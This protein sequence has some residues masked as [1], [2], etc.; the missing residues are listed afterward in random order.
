MWNVYLTFCSIL[1]HQNPNEH[2]HPH[3]RPPSR[4]PKNQHPPYV[5][6]FPASQPPNTP[7]TPYYHI[8]NTAPLLRSGDGFQR[9]YTLKLVG[10]I[11]LW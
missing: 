1:Q 3:E 6:T 8:P 9:Q 10:G 5:P 11:Y 2:V 4:Y 7:H